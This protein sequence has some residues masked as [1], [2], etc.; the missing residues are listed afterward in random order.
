[1]HADHLGNTG[2]QPYTDF[3]LKNFE[4]AVIANKLKWNGIEHRKVLSWFD[5]SLNMIKK[6]FFIYVQLFGFLFF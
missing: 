2:Y 6:M 5:P 1:M 3:V 4:W